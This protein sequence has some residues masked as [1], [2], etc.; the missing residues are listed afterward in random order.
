MFKGRN[1]YGDF[2]DAGEGISTN[3]L[4][5][6][7]AKL[8]QN[9]IISKNTD[10]IKRSKKYYRLTNKGLEL[11]PIMLKIIEWSQKYDEKT[12]VPDQFIHDLKTDPV[13]LQKRL[14]NDLSYD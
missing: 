7:L 3:I 9:G 11:L 14:L 6:R 1:Y 13:Q 4:A 8:E 12:E 2:L 5:D 10:P